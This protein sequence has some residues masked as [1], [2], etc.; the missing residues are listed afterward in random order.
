MKK[1][2]GQCKW[3]GVTEEEDEKGFG[4]KQVVWSDR[5][6]GCKRIWVKAGGL[7]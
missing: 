5:R 1:D 7:E 6:G 4:S 3:S 2:L